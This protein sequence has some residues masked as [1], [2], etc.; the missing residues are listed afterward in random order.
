L[1]RFSGKKYNELPL[2]LWNFNR[3]VALTNKYDNGKVPTPN[4]FLKLTNWTLQEL[5]VP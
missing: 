4:D 3:V 1:E 5:V 2:F